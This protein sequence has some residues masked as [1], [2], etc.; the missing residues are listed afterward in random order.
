MKMISLF[1]HIPR[2]VTLLENKRDQ[3]TPFLGSKTQGHVVTLVLAKSYIEYL[4]PPPTPRQ[5]PP[6]ST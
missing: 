4:P 3:K 6:P 5:T 1:D 2:K